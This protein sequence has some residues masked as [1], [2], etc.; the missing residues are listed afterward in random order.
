MAKRTCRHS[1]TKGTRQIRRGKTR[2]QVKAMAERLGVPVG[3]P[4]PAP[5]T[6]WATIAPADM[7]SLTQ[8]VCLWGAKGDAVENR[9]AD[10]RVCRVRVEVLEV[11]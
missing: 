10:E 11:L 9:D 3:V 7:W 4:I 8:R 5:F 2:D 1:N 6:T